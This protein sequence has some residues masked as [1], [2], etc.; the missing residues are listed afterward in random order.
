MGPVVADA[1]VLIALSN[2]GLLDLLEQLVGE[3]VIPPAVAR[4]VTASMSLP[5]WVLTQALG[6]PLDARVRR[7][8]LHPG[9][10]EAIGLALEISAGRLI[11]DDLPARRL[12]KTLGLSIVGT[13]GLA[14]LA[15]R[16]GLV[17]LVRPVLDALRAK[18][19]RLRQDVYE[20]ILEASGEGKV[21]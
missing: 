17:P 16:K 3:L 4:E 13:A 12:A 20:E 21:M 2:I 1:S 7:A 11:L 9:E 5:P 6:R 18:G 14:L 19:F 8:S 10:S 15:K